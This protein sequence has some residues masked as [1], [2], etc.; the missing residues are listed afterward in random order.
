MKTPCF[1]LLTLACAL[2]VVSCGPF[3]CT[4]ENCGDGCCSANNECVVYRGDSECGPNGG[5]CERCA[6]GSVCRLDQQA[7][8]AGVMRTRVQ[9]RWAVI[10]EVDPANGEAWDSDGSPPDV[11]VEMRC[12]STSERTRT[13]ES[14]SWEP[15]WR[16]G[17]CEVI[18]S[19][20]LRYPIEI[21]IFDN[22][23]FI[24]DDEFGTIHYQ[25]TPADLNLG[26]IDIAIPRAVERLVIDLTH[27][28]SAR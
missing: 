25:V 17:S 26:R 23:D 21:S 27:S 18:T 12:P 11:V 16:T 15:R 28:Y 6:D 22:D 20:L 2:A 5:A 14:E 19:N 1:L 4:P 24:F 7:C 8:F 13:E 10:A 3:D 9:P